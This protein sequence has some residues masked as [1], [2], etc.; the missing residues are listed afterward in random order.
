MPLLRFSKFD[1]ASQYAKRLVDYFRCDVVV[2]R[3]EKLWEIHHGY[4][5]RVCLINAVN[6]FP[7]VISLIA[8]DAIFADSS[9]WTEYSNYREPSTEDYEDVDSLSTWTQIH[10]EE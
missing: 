5:G 3:N 8:D 1:L 10:L 6:D 2:R 9:L 4:C 7:D